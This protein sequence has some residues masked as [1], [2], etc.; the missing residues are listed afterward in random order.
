MKARKGHLHAN[1][2]RLF[3]PLREVLREHPNPAA[4]TFNPKVAG[5]KPARPTSEPNSERPPE[6]AH[7]D[8]RSHPTS[9]AGGTT[10]SL[11]PPRMRQQ[12]TPD[13]AESREHVTATQQDDSHTRA[14]NHVASVRDDELEHAMPNFERS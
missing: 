13:G 10:E 5:S 4:S 1:G 14:L 6:S 8:P 9:E 7:F 11:D 3:T 12:R 2:F